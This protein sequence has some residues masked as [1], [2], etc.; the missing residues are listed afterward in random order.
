MNASSE[1]SANEHLKCKN[2][3]RLKLIRLAC[4]FI[5]SVKMNM[6]FLSSDQNNEMDDRKEQAN[7][8]IRIFDLFY[9]PNH[10]VDC[11]EI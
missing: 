1:I 11:L 10:L 2:T 4:D 9:H 5:N 8:F 3:I 6:F 7:G